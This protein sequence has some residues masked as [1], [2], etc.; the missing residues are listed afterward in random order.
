[1]SPKII[2]TLSRVNHPVSLAAVTVGLLA[3]LVYNRRK[4]PNWVLA[5]VALLIVAADLT[6]IIVNPAPPRT[7]H[8][9]LTVLN[10]QGHPVDDARVVTTAGSEPLKVPGGYQIEISADK[11]PSDGKVRFIA[12]EP[13]TFYRG[14]TAVVL[15]ADNNPQ[16]AINLLA[17]TEKV[18]IKGIVEDGQRNGLQGVFVTVVGST[19]NITTREGGGF[20]LAAHAPIGQQVL[21]HA[22]KKGYKSVDQWAQAGDA[23]TVLVLIR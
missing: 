2:D 15:G 10:P 4:I 13:G 18:M 1:M 9:R 21:V 11:K 14:E 12:T 6:Y 16:A 22:E 17:D 23:N 8:V 3:L 5:I 20:T 19:E 7:F